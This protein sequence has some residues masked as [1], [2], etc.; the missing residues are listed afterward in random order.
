MDFETCGWIPI[1]LPHHLQGGFSTPSVNNMSG[2]VLKQSS[3]RFT[4]NGR[5][6]Q[7]QSTKGSSEEDTYK[8]GEIDACRL[9]VLACVTYCQ[10][11]EFR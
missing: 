7:D 5:V 11:Q 8:R 6:T 2:G 1:A 9:N 4:F 3:T 10:T